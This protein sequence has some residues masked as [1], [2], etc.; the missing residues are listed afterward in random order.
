MN[1]NFFDRCVAGT[2][3]CSG[4]IGF[5]FCGGGKL[6]LAN[7]GYDTPS[8]GCGAASSIAG[9]GTGWI[10][11]EAPVLPGETA[12]VQFMVWDSTD[13]VFDSSAIFDNFRWLQGTLANPKTYRG[14]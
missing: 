1:L 10:T 9:G 2:T 6:E 5:N 7:S 12:T 8:P 13:G 3:G 14:P 4:V 11:T